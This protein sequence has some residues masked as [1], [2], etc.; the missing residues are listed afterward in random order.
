VTTEADRFFTFEGPLFTWTTER[1][2][3]YF[4]EVPTS[5]TLPVTHGWGRT[6]VIVKENTHQFTTS[7][8]R[9]KSGRTIMPVPKNVRRGRPEGTIVTFFIRL[10]LS[11]VDL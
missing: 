1:A 5:I 8:W 4:I 7:V 2:T 6:P 11:R 3:W 9:E 10:D